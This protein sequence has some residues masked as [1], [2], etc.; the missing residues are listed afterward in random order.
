[1]GTLYIIATPIGN[2]EEITIRALRILQEVDV[3][4]CEDTRHTT[5]LLQ[6]LKLPVKTFMRYD[7]QKEQAATSEIVEI[8]ESG[9]SVALVSDAGTPLISDPGYVLVREARKRDIPVFSVPGPSALLAALTSSGLPTDKFLFLGYPPE[10]SSHRLALFRSLSPI[11]QLIGVTYVMYCAPHKLT[12]TLEDIQQSLGDIPLVVSRELT[13][14][15]EQYW[16]G[17]VSE[18]I[19]YF[20]NP[21]GEF[22]LLLHLSDAA[23]DFFKKR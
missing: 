18:A 1:M 13:K 22:V 6:L 9:K 2:L 20:Q 7:N 17:T 23:T 8:L 12:Y 19:N 14:I 4:A 3:I 15:H 16:S 11:N 5:K 21:K 10:K